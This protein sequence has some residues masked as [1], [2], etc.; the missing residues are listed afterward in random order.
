MSPV[1]NDDTAL[2]VRRS[3]NLTAVIQIVLILGT[4]IAG[5]Y[6]F[7]FR[8]SNLERDDAQLRQEVTMMQDTLERL[9]ATLEILNTTI[10]E[11]PLHRHIRDG[12]IEY[13]NGTGGQVY[14]PQGK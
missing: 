1:L 2:V 13:P 6:K 14:R 8:V 9:N 5:W 11:Y 7:D 12:E 10:S 4:M 3:I